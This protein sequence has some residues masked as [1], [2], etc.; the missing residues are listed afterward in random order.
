[1]S[2]REVPPKVRDILQALL[3]Q[4]S[5]SYRAAIDRLLND[6]RMAGVYRTFMLK[7]S[8][9]PKRYLYEAEPAPSSPAVNDTGKVIRVRSPKDLPKRSWDRDD[10]VL[11]FLSCA[12]PVWSFGPLYRAREIER[13][14]KDLA[15][16]EKLAAGSLLAEIVAKILPRARWHVAALEWHAAPP[17]SRQPALPIYLASLAE[18]ARRAFGNYLYGI[19]ATTASVVLER[20]V[21][22]KQ[23]RYAVKALSLPDL[24]PKNPKR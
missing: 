7:R 14:R 4:E 1:M 17:G 16:L 5:I 22:E 15:T 21:S 18:A 12:A 24:P 10:C 19:V 6:E 23:V 2:I 8:N 3:A 11:Y 9:D 20:D 13:A